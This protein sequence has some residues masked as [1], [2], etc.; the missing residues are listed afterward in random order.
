MAK[1][2]LTVELEVDP[3]SGLQPFFT[4]ND[5]TAGVLDNTEFTLGG[6]SF[7]DVTENVAGVSVSRGISRE[8]D[9]PTAGNASVALNNDTRLFDPLNSAS[10]YSSQLLPHR[11]IRVKANGTAVFLGIVEDWN[12]QYDLAGNNLSIANASDKFTLLAQQSID[13]LVVPD[14]L[15][16]ARLTRILNLPEVDWSA[17]ERNIDVGNAM[18]QLGL[19]KETVIN[20]L[21][22][23]EIV[24]LNK[25]TSTST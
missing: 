21:R 24:E 3:D 1:P 22:S 6:L 7:A 17:T 9:R 20:F 10:P 14:E 18:F 25:S 11:Q 5:P 23:P 4:L 15:T 16:S 2:I 8:L 19:D 13:E 12:L